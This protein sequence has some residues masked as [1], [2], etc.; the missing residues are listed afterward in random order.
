MFFRPE[1]DLIG[2]RFAEIMHT[3]FRTQE[4][5]RINADNIESWLSWVKQLQRLP[6]FRLFEVNLVD[7]RWFLFLQQTLPGGDM[8]T[9]IAN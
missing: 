2:Q 8:L 3:A 7:G 1:G 5:P 6:D 4:G 9:Q